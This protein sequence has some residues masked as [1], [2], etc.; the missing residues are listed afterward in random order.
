[1][2][3]MFSRLD[4]GVCSGSILEAQKDTRRI[5]QVCTDLSSSFG[6]AIFSTYICILLSTCMYASISYLLQRLRVGNLLRC[7]PTPAL[8]GVMAS[9]GTLC[10]EC[11]YDEIY[12]G[13][14]WRYMHYCFG[15]SLTLA[16]LV[17]WLDMRF[18][19]YFLMVPTFTFVVLVVFHIT[20]IVAGKDMEWLRTMNLVP[21][22]KDVS[23]A[24]TELSQ[25][26]RMLNVNVEAVRANWKNIVGLALFN[27]IHIAVNVP[28]FAESMGIESNINDEL[29][30][31][32]IGGLVSGFFGY[33]TY[34]I[35][36]TSIYFNKSGGRSR[37]HS[38]VGGLALCL[39]L[40]IGS[41]VRCILP[42]V[43]IAA[44]PT[45]IGLSFLYSYLY[46]PM[47]ELSYT[48]LVVLLASAA[49][50]WV[51]MPVYGLVLGIVIN[52]F[53]ILLSYSK[54]V[55]EERSVDR[56]EHMF[57]NEV[58]TVVRIDFPVFF[59]TVEKF[60]EKV[61]GLFGSVV[62]DL[63]NCGYVD[64]NGN[65]ILKGVLDEIAAAGHQALILGHP[66]NLYTHLFGKHMMNPG[67]VGSL[68]CS[69]VNEV[70]CD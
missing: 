7:I 3:G 21:Q 56:A 66:S 29:G 28:S 26:F 32:S 64:A 9:I 62:F 53:H 44:I 45:F 16:L 47:F 19:T 52:S 35:C 17:A 11:G 2:F 25:H 55:S 39:L 60:K 54:F 50:S 58:Y 6:E 49:M 15:I 63:R 41:A 20:F 46:R 36:S 59:G 34:F 51:T 10:M 42:T 27:L 69:Q 40:F 65:S 57:G 24:F 37:V 70:T 33:P 30:T 5:H 48:D 23:L 31:Q 8:Y 68:V 22:T 1:M 12:R 38:I 13:E 67:D 14:P 18:P 61:E 43:L 4:G